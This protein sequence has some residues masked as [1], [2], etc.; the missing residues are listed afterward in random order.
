MESWHLVRSHAAATGVETTV[1][2]C[3]Q[4]SLFR[5]HSTLSVRVENRAKKKKGTWQCPWGA[6]ST[7][8]EY[9]TQGNSSD[10]GFQR[11]SAGQNHNILTEKNEHFQILNYRIKL[12]NTKNWA[13]NLKVSNEL[14]E[15]T[16]AWK[17]NE[18]ISPP[19]LVAPL[20]VIPCTRGLLVWFLV[21]G[22]YI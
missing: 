17:P 15:R 22:S 8:R 21:K 19:S 5:D 18:E 4:C 10:S 6:S 12:F 20:G 16:V 7:R 14:K 2:P 13:S 11:T 3:A 1:A 9:N